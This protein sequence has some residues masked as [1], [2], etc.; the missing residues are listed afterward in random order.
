MQSPAFSTSS[1]STAPTSKPLTSTLL[2]SATEAT[3]LSL[4]LAEAERSVQKQVL[5]SDFFT[6]HL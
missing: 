6:E 4:L 1:L 2:G 3:H 5:L